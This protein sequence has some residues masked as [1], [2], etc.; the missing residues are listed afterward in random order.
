MHLWFAQIRKMKIRHLAL[1]WRT[2]N[3]LIARFVNGWFLKVLES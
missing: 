2:K 1:D 3:P